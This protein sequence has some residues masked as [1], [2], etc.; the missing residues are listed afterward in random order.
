MRLRQCPGVLDGEARGVSPAALD[1]VLRNDRVH[2]V[3]RETA[4]RPGRRQEV[5][6]VVLGVE[7]RDECLGRGHCHHF[8]CAFVCV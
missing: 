4:V 5:H 6:A 3:Q 8:S 2:N 7:E 1:V